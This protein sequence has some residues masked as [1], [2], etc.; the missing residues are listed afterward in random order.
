MQGNLQISECTNEAVVDLGPREKRPD[1]SL[2]IPPRAVNFENSRRGKGLLQSQVSIKGISPSRSLFRDLSFKKKSILP[3]GERSSLLNSDS[4]PTAESPRFANFL[5][6]F[7]WK[8]CTSL[9]VS[10]EPSKS[11]TV[12]TPISARLHDEHPRSHVRSVIY[13]GLCNFSEQ[14]KLVYKSQKV[15]SLVEGEIVIWLCT[16]CFFGVVSWKLSLDNCII[17]IYTI[18]NQCNKKD[19]NS[20]SVSSLLI[21]LVSAR[22]FILAYSGIEVL[23]CLV[24]F[25]TILWSIAIIGNLKRG[26]ESRGNGLWV[27][28]C[29]GIERQESAWISSP[30]NI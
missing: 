17:L 26:T 29:C 25:S 8:R 23:S 12:A 24:N 18:L 3:D 13:F 21:G 1:L 6:A 27:W 9:P 22:Q 14:F 5:G 7:T 15:D 11:P 28:T 4:K 30:R 2:Q 10:H 20:W 19:R 16:T